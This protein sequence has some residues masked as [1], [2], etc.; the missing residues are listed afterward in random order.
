MIT[1]WTYIEEVEGYGCL[2]VMDN[3]SR[4]QTLGIWAELI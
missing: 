2:G 1:I 4:I 3:C